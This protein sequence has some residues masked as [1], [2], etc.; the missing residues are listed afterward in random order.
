M[1]ESIIHEAQWG[2]LQDEARKQEERDRKEAGRGRGEDEGL[3]ETETRDREG[4]GKRRRERKRGCRGRQQIDR[5]LE[6]PWAV[7]GLAGGGEGWGL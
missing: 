4:R 5:S 1:S 7:L 2:E 6:S 3:R